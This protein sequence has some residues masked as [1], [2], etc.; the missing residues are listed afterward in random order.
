MQR[1]Q[2][3]VSSYIRRAKQFQLIAITLLSLVHHRRMAALP[4]MDVHRR[5]L[6]MV[7]RRQPILARRRHCTEV[8]RHNTIQVT[9]S[10]RISITFQSQWTRISIESIRLSRIYRKP[11]SWWYDTVTRWI[12]DTKR[13]MGSNRYQY[14]GSINRIRIL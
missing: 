4:L 1:P 3:H 12:D 2:Q 10:T 14:A 9:Y 11:Y 5:V 13:C 8:Q 7:H 6:H